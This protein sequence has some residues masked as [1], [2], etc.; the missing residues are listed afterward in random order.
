MRTCST[1]AIIGVALLCGCDDKSKSADSTKPESTRAEKKSLPKDLPRPAKSKAVPPAKT[2]KPESKSESKVEPKLAQPAPQPE[3]DKPNPFTWPNWLGP[4]HD[5]VSLETGWSSDWP[6]DGLPLKWK[7]EI[8]IGFSSVAIADGRLFTMGHIDGDEIVWCLDVNTADVIWSHRYP[9]S[10]NANLHEGGPGATPTIDGELVYTLGKDGQ[11]FCLKVSDGSVVWQKQLQSD[12]DVPL[13]E[14]GFASSAYILGDQLLL[15][16][17]RVVSY[18]KKSGKKNWQTEVHEAGYGSVTPFK[19][20]EHT[21]L[22]TLDCEVLRITNSANGKHVADYSWPSPFGTNSTTPIVHDGR[23]F[24]SSGYQVGC[25]LF[26]LKMKKL[27]DDN[28]APDA[29]LIAE[30]QPVYTNRD[31][32]NHFNNSILWDGHLYG[33]DGNSNLGRV[34]TLTCMEM[35]S[36]DVKWKHRGLGCG[37]LMVADGKLVILSEKGTLIIAEVSPDEFNEVARSSFLTG[38]CWTVPV[39]VGGHIY[40]RNAR[41]TLVSVQLPSSKP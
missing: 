33:F 9:G 39:L 37:S 24:I 8:G 38:R 13:P 31:M 17:G 20:G 41:G 15:Q 36:G 25:G 7:R 12:L 29:D 1:L 18:D 3:P 27:P 6:P 32:R 19:W 16:G 23:I 10:L 21:L 22:A 26:E 14:W 28:P 35:K 34:V 40:G 30:L 2:H 11:L 5:G 4:N